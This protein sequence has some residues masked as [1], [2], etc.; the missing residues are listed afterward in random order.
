MVTIPKEL[1][2]DTYCAICALPLHYV[3]FRD[4]YIGKP[5]F[6][7]TQAQIDTIL[8]FHHGVSPFQGLYLSLKEAVRVTNA[9]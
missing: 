4:K 2:E 6:T 5:S 9:R 3:A 1:S 7:F 8:G